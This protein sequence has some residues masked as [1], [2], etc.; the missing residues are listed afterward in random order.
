VKAVCLALFLLLAR[1]PARGE[2]V[3]DLLARTRQRVIEF[4]DEFSDVKCTEQ[5]TQEKLK[6]DGKVELREQSTFDY[7][8]LMTSSGGELNLNESRLPVHEVAGKNRK[9]LP[10]LVSNGFATLFLVFHPYYA[11]GFEFTDLGEETAGGVR[12]RKIGFHHVHDMRTPLALALRGREFPLDPEG[13]AW[14]DPPNRCHHPHVRQHRK[15]PRRHRAETD[16]VGH[17]VCSRDLP[18]QE[19]NVLVPTPGQRRS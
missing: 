2:P 6:A 18:R 13:E 3:Q 4:L 19:R 15:G 8:V 14:I 11:S 5:V 17:W 12:L 7:L 10:L 16:A 9:N 1:V